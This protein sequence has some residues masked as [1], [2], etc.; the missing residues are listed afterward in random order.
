MGK[1]LGKV[2]LIS[3]WLVSGMVLAEEP[4]FRIAGAGCCN[5]KGEV[6]LTRAEFEAL[7]QTEVKTGTPWT[8]GEHLYRGVLLRDLVRIY[9]LKSQEVKALAVNEYWAALP[10]EDGEK[11]PVLVAEKQDGKALTL[12][13][14]GPLWV[15]YPLT[16]HPELN[17]ELYHS[18]MVW[19][20]T[21]LESK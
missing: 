20:L 2:S 15:I 11:Y 12:R 14:K 1:W 19:Q 16:D 18:R 13:N 5:G 4:F 17:K 8:E 3:G 7:P 10:L 6:V 9:G 21:A